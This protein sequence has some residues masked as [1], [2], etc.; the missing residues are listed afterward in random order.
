MPPVGTA[1]EDCTWA[2]ISAIAQAG[3]AETYFSIGDKKSVHIK[4]TVGTVDID[5]TYYVTIIDFDHLS[6]NTIDF[7][8]FSVLHEGGTDIALTDGNLGK[9]STDGTK[10]FQMNHRS[11]KNTGGWK[12][13]DLRCDILGSVRE[14]GLNAGSISLETPPANTLMAALPADLRAVMKMMLV[15]TDNVAG[16]T[17][18]ASNV[19]GTY[20][21]LILPS[22]FEVCGEIFKSNPAEGTNIGATSKPK[23]KWY[24]YFADANSRK[25][26]KDT[27][28]DAATYW[29]LRSPYATSAANFC[30]VSTSGSVNN[31]G[32]AASMARGISPIFRV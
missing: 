16:N 7:M 30:V 32:N 6:E 23:Q 15:Y 22:E 11:N 1:L 29:L 8:A 27:D 14:K 24:T 18:D 26:Y 4:G 28:P 31:G 3:L 19:T 13:C 9:S 25:K 10:Y 2:E 17:Q 21:Y 20:D 5:A 12:D